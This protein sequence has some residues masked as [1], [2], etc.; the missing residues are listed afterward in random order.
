ML[1]NGKIVW[2]HD[3]AVVIENRADSCKEYVSNW[4]DFMWNFEKNN[5]FGETTIICFFTDSA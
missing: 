3:I 1:K 5:T 4:S 2:K